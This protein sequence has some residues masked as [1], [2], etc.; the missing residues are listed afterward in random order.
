[1]SIPNMLIMS[2]EQQNN[3]KRSSINLRTVLMMVSAMLVGFSAGAV[4]MTLVQQNSNSNVAVFKDTSVSASSDANATNNDTEDLETIEADGTDEN[5]ETTVTTVPTT[6]TPVTTTTTLNLPTPLSGEYPDMVV[7]KLDYK[8][9]V[10]GDKVVYLTFD[11]GPW[12]GTPQ[13]LDLLDQYGVKATFFVTAQF[14]DEEEDLVNAIKQI[15]DRGHEVAVHTYL[16]EYRDIYASVDAYLEDYKKM[17]DIIVKAIGTRSHAF[18]FPG[19]SNNVYDKDIREDLIRE[20]N[21]RGL[22]YYDWNA[23]DGGCDGYSESQMI[24]SAVEES[25]SQDSSIL[26]MHDTKAQSFILD[27]LPSIISQLQEAGYRF[28]VLDGTVKPVQFSKVEDDEDEE[29]E[30]EETTITT[31]DDYDNED[32]ENEDSYSD[33]DDNNDDD[34]DDDD[35]SNEDDSDDYDED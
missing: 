5:S 6:T 4:C 32:D 27:T 33:D 21:S 18:R 11:D 15:H 34:N 29:E 16:H 35:Y 9:E 19:G 20:M 12:S 10:P 22:V 25:E 28:D 8:E 3:K 31:D 30:T 2:E 7:E 26:L 24:S 13:L 1:M 14:F 17:D 23:Y